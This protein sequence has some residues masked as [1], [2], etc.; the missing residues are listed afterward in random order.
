MRTS[1]I[2]F[3]A[4]VAVSLLGSCLATG[5]DTLRVGTEKG[6]T[7]VMLDGTPT[8]KYQEFRRIR[9]EDDVEVK[10][11]LDESTF[12]LSGITLH[13]DPD[14]EVEVARGKLATVSSKVSAIGDDKDQ[15]KIGLTY[16]CTEDLTGV[17][18]VWLK[19][20]LDGETCNT[21]GKFSYLISSLL[22]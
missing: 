3:T 9:D 14:V 22:T 2:I 13:S 4:I 18:D 20:T 15:F 6:A 10:A 1:T 11:N 19:L 7:D 17:T 16:D 21:V 8:D 5:C 12:F